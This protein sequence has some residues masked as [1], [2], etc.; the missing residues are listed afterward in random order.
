[1]LEI[2]IIIL[3][4]FLTLI[5]GLGTYAYTRDMRY[6]KERLTDLTLYQKERF[7]DHESR[8]RSLESHKQNPRRK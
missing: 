8:L 2:T 7:D 4:F 3:S 1:M 5:L 6:L